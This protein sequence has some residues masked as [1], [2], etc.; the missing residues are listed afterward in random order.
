MNIDFFVG[1]TS[2]IYAKSCEKVSKRG[3]M[4]DAPTD[5]SIKTT[6]KSIKTTDGSEAESTDGQWQSDVAEICD[7]MEGKG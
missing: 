2:V 7:R 4:Y 3:K 1:T 6:Q 5:E